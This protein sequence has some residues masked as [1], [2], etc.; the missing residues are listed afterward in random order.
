MTKKGTE[1]SPD[2]VSPPGNTICDLLEERQ[3]TKAEL[4]RRLGQSEKHVNLL[5]SG[6]AGLTEDTAIRLERVLGGSAQFWLALESQYRE[7]IT[8]HEV[9]EEL[10]E[11]VS[12]LTYFPLREMRERGYISR[13][14]KTRETVTELLS[15]FSVASVEAWQAEYNSPSYAFR[16]SDKM[17]MNSRPVAAWLRQGERI[18]SKIGCADYNPK[19]FKSFLHDARSLTLK[20]TPIEFADIL[21]RECAKCGVAVVLLPALPKCPVSGCM[22]WLS[23]KKALLMLSD[24]FKT[25]DHFWYTFFHEAGHILLHG[26]KQIYFEGSEGKRNRLEDEADAFARNILIP[27]A[28]A[29]TLELIEH[30]RDAITTFAGK[31]GIAPGIVVGRMQHDGLLPWKSTLNSLKQNYN[32]N[33]STNCA[34]TSS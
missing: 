25:S 28:V 23:P 26:S 4:S 14:D 32:S 7:A 19:L 31:I 2:W 24:R 17:S 12:W 33:N 3:W 16:A 15:F 6:K 8:R 30:S 22:R 29:R 21:T 20:R 34:I 5:L 13:S 10:K 18:A 11:S 27:P 9:N 1:F